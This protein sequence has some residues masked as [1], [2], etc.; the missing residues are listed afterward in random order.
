M[1]LSF[2][3]AMRGWI[4]G[5]SGS[6]FPISFEVRAVQQR[7][8]HF[9][10]RGLLSA[11]PLTRETPTEGTLQLGP[12]TLV[13]HLDFTAAD[14]RRLAL[15]AVKHPSV[16]A[17]LRSMTRMQAT[18]RDEAGL[19]VASGE[20]RFALR[21]MPAFVTSWLPVIGGGHRELDARRRQ[22]ERLALAG[23]A[24]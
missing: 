2:V 5:E 8:R 19:L 12:T 11:P 9:A 15:D 16:L 14:G 4:R 21:D 3:E 23:S 13:Y 24:Q 22:V 10:I 6:E 20:M 1:N 18:V 17:P 7:G